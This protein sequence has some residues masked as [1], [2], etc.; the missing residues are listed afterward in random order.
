MLA[1]HMEENLFLFGEDFILLTEGKWIAK[2]VDFCLQSNSLCL[3]HFK[4][5]I[6]AQKTTPEVNG[7]YVSMLL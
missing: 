7:L 2:E 5:K 4:I 6:L 1:R 3:H